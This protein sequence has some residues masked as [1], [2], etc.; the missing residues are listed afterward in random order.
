MTALLCLEQNLPHMLPFLRAL[1]EAGSRAAVI[2]QVAGIMHGSTDPTEDLDLLWDGT[3]PPPS[4]LSSSSSP[5]SPFS[6]ER[7]LRAALTA[8]GC[9]EL[10]DLSL[11]Q[12]AYTVDGVFG[13]LCSTALP[14]GGLDTAACL[15]RALTA[16]FVRYVTL[17]DLIAMR[18]AIGRPKDLRR[19]AELET[20]QLPRMEFAFPGPLR[21][22]LVA[23]V[24]SGA[25]TTTTALLAGYE[26]D[27]KPL[28]APGQRLA[29]IDSTDRPVA[30]IELTE[31]RVLRLADVDLQHVLDEGE[32]DESV[33]QWRAGHTEFWTSPEIRAE[34]PDLTINDETLIVAKRFRLI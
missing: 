7:A 11:P 33:A 16:G 17:P 8:A 29:V 26:L 5:P 10:P 23:A 30:T 22:Q 28:P 27:G 32:G 25:K 9:T 14:W 4:F 34:L 21:D 1:H 19:A 13:D 3:A 12:V 6:Q 15:D 31:V 24:L 20:L 2:G 18:R